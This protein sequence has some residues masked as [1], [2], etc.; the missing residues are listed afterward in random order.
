MLPA[1]LPFGA[2]F[3]PMLPRPNKE[4]HVVVGVPLQLPK[5]SQPSAEDVEKWHGKY[6]AQ[7]HELYQRH[8]ERAYGKGTHVL[9]VW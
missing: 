5:I 6:T 1:I 2:W 9:E 8:A 4:L 3:C 7:L